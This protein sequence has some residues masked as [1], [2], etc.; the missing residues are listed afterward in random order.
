MTKE[1][2]IRV[3]KNDTT[4]ID[5]GNISPNVT[6]A[7]DIVHTKRDQIAILSFSLSN[8]NGKYN[9]EFTN[10]NDIQFFVKLDGIS[11]SKRFG[12]EIIEVAP[13]PDNNSIRI[14]CRGRNGVLKERYWS[15]VAS[16][17]DLGQH[18]K[19]VLD[20]KAAELDT[21]GINTSTGIIIDEIKV[22]A[23][24]VF[25]HFEDLFREN[26]YQLDV[27]PDNV[28]NLFESQKGSSGITLSDGDGGNV[29]EGTNRL[30]DSSLSV[31]NSVTVI[32]G[33][34]RIEDFDED[35]ITWNTGDSTIIVLSNA[36]DT[37]KFVKFAGITKVEGTDFEITSDRKGIKLITIANGNTVDIRYDFL[38]PV[39]WR[40]QDISATKLREFV[41]KD[42]T[43]LTQQRAENI[44]K[45]TLSKILVRQIK[46]DIT[47]G[48]I[49]S[50]FE[51]YQTLELST[52]RFTGTHTIVGFTET[53][54]QDYEVTYELAQV[55]DENTKKILQL[56]K[57]VDKLKDVDETTATIKD[58][59][60]L[61]DLYAITEELEGFE[62]GIGTR[63]FWDV[64]DWDDGKTYDVG[65]GTETQF[66]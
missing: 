19:N 43:I 5:F 1:Y 2:R 58:G 9:N 65:E 57:D 45:T 3:T 31:K 41:I 51:W 15:G 39:W 55:L 53:F 4:T 7:F 34:E 25:D 52:S 12:G 42:D 28:V 56:I 33:N 47:S 64:S 40:E 10:F 59:F 20:E 26:N 22:D 54:Q 8:P 36:I 23:Q 32:G 49:D 13:E 44:A 16:N 48:L 21:T 24:L 17:I 46:G 61:E 14:T 60:F 29:K 66:L 6:E 63:F 37:L 30:I 50:E 18:I 27:D 35:Q 38:S 62:T 11:E